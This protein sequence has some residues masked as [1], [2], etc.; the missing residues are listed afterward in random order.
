MN[1]AGPIQCLNTHKDMVIY[2]WNACSDSDLPGFTQ[3]NLKCACL[4]S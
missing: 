2:A 1:E 3:F 4:H